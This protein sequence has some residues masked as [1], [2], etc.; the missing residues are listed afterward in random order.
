M[1]NN[2]VKY[3][4][5]LGDNALILGHRNSE[6]C[7]HGPVL[8]QDIA[9]SNIALDL[10]GQARNF[11]QYAANAFN[12]LPKNEQEAFFISPLIAEKVK[13]Q[14]PITEDDLA[15]LRDQ[16]DYRNCN[17]LELPKGNWA[18]TVLRQYFYANFSSLLFNKILT[19]SHNDNLNAIISK[20]LKE[21]KYHISW[22]SQWILRLG[23][24]T[25][26]SHAKTQEALDYLYP[27]AIDLFLPSNY[28]NE[29]INSHQIPSLETIKEAWLVSTNDL[30]KEA[31][32]N[33]PEIQTQVLGHGKNALHTEHLSY[34]LNELQVVH[35]A[36]P[37]STW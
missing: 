14:T 19:I 26:E 2:L 11:Y 18:H 12:Q 5:H 6:W 35:R 23:D 36:Y 9:I 13:E 34:L 33:I 7:G 1:D 24:G 8:E 15:Y 32:L 3:L 28:E 25:S 37:N 20:S 30:L 17:L 21:I 29:L 16:E 4:L 31:T 22:S 27:Y 10:L